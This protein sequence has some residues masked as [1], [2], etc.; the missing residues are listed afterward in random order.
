MK[1]AIIFFNSVFTCNVCCQCKRDN[2]IDL[3]K[4]GDCVDV[5]LKD[6]NNNPIPNQYVNLTIDNPSEP[7]KHMNHKSLDSQ[8]HS[9]FYLG[10]HGKFTIKVVYEGSDKYEPSS[11]VTAIDVG[12][13][14]NSIY[15]IITGGIMEQWMITSMILAGLKNSMMMP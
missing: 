10:S 12:K 5:K 8:G 6:S 11:N 14:R 1:K 2:R 3:K 15:T 4:D 13:A 9:K 7:V